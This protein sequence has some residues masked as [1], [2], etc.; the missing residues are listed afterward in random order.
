LWTQPA[1][2]EAEQNQK[3]A[4]QQQIELNDLKSRFITMA[5]HEFRTP[6]A[7]IHGSSTC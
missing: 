1:R 5:S 7:T 4:L 2:V 6:L 3:R